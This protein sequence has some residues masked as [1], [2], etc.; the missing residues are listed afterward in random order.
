MTKKE[1]LENYHVT[2]D[3]DKVEFDQYGR[4]CY[5]DEHGITCL[6][7]KQKYHYTIDN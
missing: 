7:R 1:L 5:R 6:S 4:P 2:C 3:I